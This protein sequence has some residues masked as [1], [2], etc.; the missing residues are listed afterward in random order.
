M[1]EHDDLS[2][3][4]DHVA[5]N[6]SQLELLCNLDP[7]GQCTHPGINCVPLRFQLLAFSI[8][9]GKLYRKDFNKLAVLELGLEVLVLWPVHV[10]GH[11]DHSEIRVTEAGI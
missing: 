10:D 11:V 3:T 7:L 1:Q 5:S 9:V 2:A 8:Q 4:S 6:P